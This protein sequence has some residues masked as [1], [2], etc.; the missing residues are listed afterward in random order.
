MAR[1][2][3]AP[4]RRVLSLQGDAERAGLRVSELA[5]TLSR[6][7]GREIQWADQGNEVLN[8]DWNPDALHTVRAIAAY[9]EYPTRG[10][11]WRKRPFALP[12]DPRDHASLRRIF[13]GDDTTFPHL[14]R[15]SDN[16]GLWVPVDFPEPLAASEPAWWMVG[17]VPRVLQELARIEAV[18]S[19]TEQSKDALLAAHAELKAIFSA[20]AEAKLPVVI[21]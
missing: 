16:K 3:V 6:H 11:F 20:A 8:R 12:K 14:M 19:V 1:I 10:I 21:D 17:S 7:A 18:I 9:S 15:H 2:R 5:L 4:L 13:D